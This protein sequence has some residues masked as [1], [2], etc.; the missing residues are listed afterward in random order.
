MCVYICMCICICICTYT[1]QN[2]SSVG[3]FTHSEQSPPT[4]V[5]NQGQSDG[6]SSSIV[7]PSSQICGDLCQVDTKLKQPRKYC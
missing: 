3:G 4:L 2:Y 1:T 5:I 7:I 6:S